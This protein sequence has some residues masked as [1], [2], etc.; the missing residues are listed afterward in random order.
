MKDYEEF[1]GE[2]IGKVKAKK[3][4][5][6]KR[7]RGLTVAL[8]CVCIVLA[9]AVTLTHFAPWAG[10][11]HPGQPPAPGTVSK[12]V[13]ELSSKENYD[14]LY[15]MLDVREYTVFD[16][17]KDRLLNGF[18]KNAVAD[19]AMPESEN[20]Y[21]QK[22][23]PEASADMIATT[24]GQTTESESENVKHTD[25]NVQVEGID[26]ADAV[27]T[28]GKYIY[29]V[30]YENVYIYAVDGGEMTLLSKIPFCGEDSS[31]PH[32]DGAKT[33]L[34]SD[35]AQCGMCIDIY[36]TDSRLV[37]VG[38]CFDLSR[39]DAT[40]KMEDSDYYY[41]DPRRTFTYAAV[42][43]ITDRANPA[44]MHTAAVSG[45][46]LSTR[47]KGDVL[48]L[49][50]SEYIYD[51]MIKKS[52]PETFAPMWADDSGKSTVSCDSIYCG[53]SKVQCRYLNVCAVDTVDAATVSTLSLLGYTGDNMY[54]SA[55]AIYAAQ[56]EWDY[57]RAHTEFDEEP[58]DLE[59]K[60]ANMAYQGPYTVF[61]KITVGDSLELA[62]D[63]KVPGRLIN[64]FAMDEYDGYFRV[65]VTET[66]EVEVT[67]KTDFGSEVKYYEYRDMNSLYVLDTELKVVG[68]V[69]GIAPNEQIYSV[70][71]DGDTAYMVTYR[72]MDPLFRI[73]LSD[74]TSPKITGELEMPGYST[75]LHKFS[76]ALLFGFGQTDDGRLKI[77]MYKVTDGE[78]MEEVGYAEIT[79]EWWSEA[80]SNHHAIVVDTESGIIGFPGNFNYYVYSFGESGFVREALLPL[81]I[82]TPDSDFIDKNGDGMADWGS[83]TR[84]MFI[85]DHL[86]ITSE[87]GINSYD[88]TEFALCDGEIMDGFDESRIYYYALPVY[89][90]D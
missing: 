12:S 59:E 45:N 15:K 9:G 23:D 18:A 19:E 65:G 50:S 80:S 26:E 58:A 41:R 54:Q 11:D 66:G 24:D 51:E 76:D 16:K 64:Q 17:V 1:T 29:A 28:D 42:Y 79:D 4:E 3:A 6:A 36:L 77:A 74:P 75:Y 31:L 69:R 62:A 70:R 85:G 14:E 61:A 8:S 25:T 2:V 34:Y 40:K 73:D 48:Y 10:G 46:M 52:D 60:D 43:D 83:R 87:A 84:A 55:D 63:G 53:E 21:G 86:F 56:T 67:E 88:T 78:D 5:K 27:K 38:Q 13:L 33:L 49:V 30:S 44:F 35:H 7:I 20:L 37:V 71:F 90:W 89:Y 81:G 22:V 32:S 57:S 47:M 72:N 82:G 39:E 68:S